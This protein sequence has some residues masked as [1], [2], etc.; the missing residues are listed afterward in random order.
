[1]KNL[2]TIL[3]VLLV[4]LT[5]SISLA[6]Q[7]TANRSKQAM[8][9]FLKQANNPKTAIAEKLQKTRE[10]LASGFIGEN[11]V[12]PNPLKS[13]D[14][15]IVE[16]ASELYVGTFRGSEPESDKGYEQRTFDVYVIATDVSYGGRMTS[17]SPV[18]FQCTLTTKAYDAE[19]A[20]V[21]CL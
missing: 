3:S 19:L 20:S 7:A 11:D 17:T 6:A 21:T 10:D 9:F 18:K 15:K 14:V 5:L 1:M 4:A 16:S 2:L 13:K 8:D 12:I